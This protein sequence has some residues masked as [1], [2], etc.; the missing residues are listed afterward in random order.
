M[1]TPATLDIAMVSFEG[2][3]QYSQA[4]GLGVRANQ[5]CRAFAAMGFRTSLYFVG[6]PDEPF[7]E[8]V[9]GLRLV[10]IA[11]SVSRR[12][13]AG[14]YDGEHDKIEQMW[15]ELPPLIRDGSG[16][17]DPVRGVADGRLRRDPRPRAA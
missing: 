15:H 3:D 5:M 8:T 6:D 17:G 2:P 1:F 12:H 4:G 14:V 10:R 7:E 9:D 13:P 16:A 11:Q